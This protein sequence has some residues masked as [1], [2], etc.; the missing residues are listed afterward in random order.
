MQEIKSSSSCNGVFVLAAIFAFAISY[1]S[2]DY[3][4]QKKSGYSLIQL[5]KVLNQ[6]QR[7]KDDYNL[8]NKTY[9]LFVN[10]QE[11]IF[12]FEGF[13][14]DNLKVNGEDIEYKILSGNKINDINKGK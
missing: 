12:S 2:F 4:F 1:I 14:L 7:K 3:Y 9:K 8:T 6:S 10:D 5:V 11:I 13:K